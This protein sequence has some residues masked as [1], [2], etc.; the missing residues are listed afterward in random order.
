MVPASLFLVRIP[1][2]LSPEG[3]FA[4]TGF[5]AGLKSSIELGILQCPCGA[6]APLSV[7]LK[8]VSV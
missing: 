7:G 8:G 6:V 5:A 3:R 2:V 4:L 1:S